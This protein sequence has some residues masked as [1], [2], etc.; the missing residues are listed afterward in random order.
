MHI[1]KHIQYI[2]TYFNV[3]NH[4]WWYSDTVMYAIQN[5][6]CQHVVG[7]T[8]LYDT[9]W[10]V[11]KTYSNTFQCGYKYSNVCCTKQIVSACGGKIMPHCTGSPSMDWNLTMS[12]SR[13]DDPAILSWALFWT[14][15]NSFKNLLESY[16]PFRCLWWWRWLDKSPPP[17]VHEHEKLS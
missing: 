8:F 1:A 3:V 6:L 15:L 5:K 2:E 7:N 17:L 16:G 11:Y 12:S 4:H 10:T 14:L 13:W 9:I